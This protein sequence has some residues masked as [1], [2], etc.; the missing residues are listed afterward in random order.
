MSLDAAYAFANSLAG[1]LMVAIIIF[2]AGDGTL[3]VTPC[4]EFDGTV[5]EV[6]IVECD[7]D[8]G[9]L[10]ARYGPIRLVLMPGRRMCGPRLLHEELVVEEIDVLR[11]HQPG[12]D[13]VHILGP[14]RAGRVVPFSALGHR[15]DQGDG[16]ALVP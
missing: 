6:D 14:G 5:A 9:D 3:S 11:T 16:F 8:R 1:T 15:P 12:R 10:P 13:L 2:R 7:P 4:N